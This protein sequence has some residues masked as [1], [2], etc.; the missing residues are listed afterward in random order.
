MCDQVFI[1]RFFYLLLSV[2]QGSMNGRKF[3][4]EDK[5][6]LP[7]FEQTDYPNI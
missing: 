1:E 5:I 2:K 3:K 6:F 4:S 7:G